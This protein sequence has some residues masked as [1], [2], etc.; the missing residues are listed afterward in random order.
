[1]HSS[2]AASDLQLVLASS[3]AL[4]EK[5]DEEFAAKATALERTV[6]QREAGAALDHTTPRDG[7]CTEEC[8]VVTL[9]RGE[10]A[11]DHF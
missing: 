9:R 8:S 7:H 6:V 4:K 10:A 5:E 3:L 2:M 11:A 1:M